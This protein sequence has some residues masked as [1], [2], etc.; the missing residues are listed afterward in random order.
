MPQTSVTAPAAGQEGTFASAIG[1][2]VTS[3][4]AAEELVPGTLCVI[5]TGADTVE[6]PDLT[7]DVTGIG[8]IG[9]VLLDENRVT[10]NYSAGE[11]VP[12]AI[13]GDVWVLTEDS[14]ASG[15]APFV[16][17]AD[18]SAAPF[19]LGSFRSDADTADAVALP[20]AYWGSTQATAGGLA[21]VR[22]NMP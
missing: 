1:R 15:V 14:S 4:V 5:T 8:A 13:R 11:S 16:R 17:F 12:I 3:R 7:G 22:L 6:Q 18:A 10:A 9:I 2:D 21:I 19:E 20:N